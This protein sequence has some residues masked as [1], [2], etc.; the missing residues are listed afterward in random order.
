MAD[1]LQAGIERAENNRRELLDVRPA[2]REPSFA[3]CS[4]KSRFRQEKSC[5]C[6]EDWK[7]GGRSIGNRKRLR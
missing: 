3:R 2:E 7:I 1:E 5:T 6:F 4:G